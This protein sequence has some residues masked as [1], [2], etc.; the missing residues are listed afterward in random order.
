MDYNTL[1][2]FT[3]KFISIVSLLLVVITNGFAVYFVID[4]AKE[5]EKR[6]LATTS[7]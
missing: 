2:T 4:T 5:K 3:T 1:I 7:L 6:N